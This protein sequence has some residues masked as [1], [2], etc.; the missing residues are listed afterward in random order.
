[1]LETQALF[2]ETLMIARVLLAALMLTAAG[3]ATAQQGNTLFKNQTPRS[4]G[5][6]ITTGQHCGE[7]FEGQCR[8]VFLVQGDFTNES[9]AA[10][11]KAIINLQST[12]QDVPL[13]IYLD[14]PGGVLTG[15]LGF[16]AVVRAAGLNTI[17]GKD[18]ECF[19]ACAYAFLGGVSRRVESGGQYGVHRFFAR[20]DVKGG[21]EMSQQTMALLGVFV[22]NMGAD[23]ELIRLSASAGQRSM[24]VLTPEQ[25]RTLRVDNTFP[26][27]TPW[28][29]QT[30]NDTLEMTVT[31][32]SAFNDRRVNLLLAPEG[33]TVKLEVAFKEPKAYSV[34]KTTDEVSVAPRVSV[35]R[36]DLRS[37]Q[38]RKCVEGKVLSPWKKG[39]EERSFV[40]SY[41]L[42]LSD[43]SQLV[44]GAAGERIVVSVTPQG[45][46]APMVI[47]AT[48]SQGFSTALKAI[49]AR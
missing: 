16:G 17:V 14:S 40:S 22:Q 20:E 48:V 28:S 37:Q 46:K 35:C 7:A 18:M 11:T 29:I 38:V 27:P 41:A 13:N 4:P 15:A 8:E 42:G 19:S 5:L 2:V 36:I 45:R 21:I 25:L 30:S 12:N 1:M 31:Q 39:S 26:A 44:N 47:V 6:A 23:A 3:A 34:L 33:S 32:N 9:G 43:L 10:L 49:T 24:L